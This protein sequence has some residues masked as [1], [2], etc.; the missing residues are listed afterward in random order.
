MGRWLGT[1]LFAPPGV[2]AS[3][4]VCPLVDALTQAG[5]R[6]E[7]T[8]GAG[9]SYYDLADNELREGESLGAVVA[10]FA[11]V[12]EWNVT[13]WKDTHDLGAHDVGLSVDRVDDATGAPCCYRVGLSIL[14]MPRSS[15]HPTFAREFLAWALFVAALTHPW[16][17]WGGSSLGLF[18]RET[19]PVSGAGVA[20]VEPQPI[21]WL[22]VFGAPYVA[23]L[24]LDRLLSLPAGQAEFLAD[25]GVAV[26]L[27]AHPDAVGETAARTVAEHLGVP[28]PIS[29]APWPP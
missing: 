8:P 24:G 2:F 17:G 7:P 1:E 27:G 12:P 6:F 28:G 9:C 18:G 20:A 16:Y 11:G 10:R 3:R 29:P 23:R 21:E 4:G 13:M 25:G 5:F 26:I 22:N 19:T 14:Y 15:E